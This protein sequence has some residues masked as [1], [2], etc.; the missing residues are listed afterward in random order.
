MDVLSQQWNHYR[1]T[2]KNN[3]AYLRVNR[4]YQ[5]PFKI[6]L[7]DNGMVGLERGNRGGG[8]L[9]AGSGEDRPARNI[10]TNRSKGQEAS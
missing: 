3:C 7:K 6:A 9:G 4:L 2:T 1:S 8:R 5:T 10:F